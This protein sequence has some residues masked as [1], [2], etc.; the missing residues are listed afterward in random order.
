ML[1]LRGRARVVHL[2]LD[3]RSLP[4]VLVEVADV[5]GDVMV[6]FEGEGDEGDEA[7][8]FLRVSLETQ[9]A[10]RRRGRH[11]DLPVNHSL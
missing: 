11:G 10:F 2:L 6:G 9:M 1:L 4:D 3:V 8:W 5:A 7:D